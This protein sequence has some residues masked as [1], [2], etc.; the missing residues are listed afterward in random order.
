MRF[1]ILL[2]TIGALAGQDKPP[3]VFGTTVVDSSG[4]EGKLYFLRRDT[5]HLPNFKRMK[6]K[7]SIYVTSLSVWPQRFDQGF[8]NL[9]NRYEW[10]AI[11]YTGKFWIE[12]P[13]EYGFRL[14]S[15]DGAKLRIDGKQVIDND[16]IHPPASATASATLTRGTHDIGVDY[17][18]G[19][20]D[21]VA[22]V[23]EV[24]SPGQ[25]WRVFNCTDFKPPTDAT[26]WNKGKISDVRSWRGR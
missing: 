23:L 5:Q 13:G 17:F 8:A 15:D 25:S 7:G 9:T 14:L 24:A 1:A 3:Y 2:L 11:E 21:T 10:F 16:G 20:R 18:Q 6:P 12:T 19:P 26:E 22:L 4:L